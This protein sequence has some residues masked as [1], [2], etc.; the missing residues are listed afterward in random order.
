MSMVNA[1]ATARNETLNAQL[2]RPHQLEGVEPAAVPNHQPVMAAKI[3]VTW[4]DY[5]Q[6]MEQ[7]NSCS[8]LYSCNML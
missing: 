2:G 3:L 1:M 7:Y 5:A 4:D 8:M 6:Y